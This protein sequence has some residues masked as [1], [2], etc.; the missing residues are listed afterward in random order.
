MISERK[1]RLS[2]KVQTHME[3]KSRNAGYPRHYSVRLPVRCGP[4]NVL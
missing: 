4:T 3:S 2:N 1:F